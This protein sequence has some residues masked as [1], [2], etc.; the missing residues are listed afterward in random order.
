MPIVQTYTLP[1]APFSFRSRTVTGALPLIVQ[2]PSTQMPPFSATS[3]GGLWNCERCGLEPEYRTPWRRGDIIP[4]QLNLRDLRN[5]NAYAQGWRDSVNTTLGGW[6]IQAQILAGDCTTV[7][8]NF[9]D[10]F[11]A[12]WWVAR[13]NIF[14]DIQTLFIDTNLMPVG[15]EVFQVKISLRAATGNTII[16]TYYTELF[17]LAQCEDTILVEA[18]EP[19]QDCLMH[20]YRVPTQ[21]VHTFANANNPLGYIPTAYWNAWR[22]Y[23]EITSTGYRNDVTEND[24]GFRI[25]SRLIDVFALRLTRPITPYI[26]QILAAQ[27]RAERT[28]VDG[29]RYI[30]FGDFDQGQPVGRMFLSEIEAQKIC[31]SNSGCD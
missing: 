31:D 25:K 2:C 12:D 27:T 23:G 20:D 18:Y 17:E 9:V 10:Q 14:G 3:L 1:N 5:N 22:Y 30:N 8:Y 15:L 16:E 4:L 24:N 21:F 19:V 13:S 11:C 7:V 26:A 28:L 6:Y 29:E